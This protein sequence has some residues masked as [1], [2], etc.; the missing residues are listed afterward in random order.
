MISTRIGTTEFE[1]IQWESTLCH[2][3]WPFWDVISEKLRKIKMQK[4]ELNKLNVRSVCYDNLCYLH[5]HIKCPLYLTNNMTN[6]DRYGI[7]LS[8][9]DVSIF[10]TLHSQVT[11]K[12][13][14]SYTLLSTSHNFISIACPVF[15]NVVG[16]VHT[17]IQFSDKS[18][19]ELFCL[20]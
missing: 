10:R 15:T 3:C 6:K 5:Y 17:R 8:N 20:K 1:T 11:F 7:R 18:I 19:S 4:S 9:E 14:R 12:K 13:I 2:I 16:V